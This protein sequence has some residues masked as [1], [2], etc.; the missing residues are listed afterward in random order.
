M[1]VAPQSISACVGICWLFMVNLQVV[2]KCLP[3][4]DTSNTSTLLTD[5]REIPKQFKV[6]DA[7]L[8][9]SPEEPSIVN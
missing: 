7:K 9:Q 4:I 1:T 2:T 3:S 8:L 6:F 5:K